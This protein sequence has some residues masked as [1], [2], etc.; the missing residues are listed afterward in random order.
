MLKVFSF[1][2][3]VSQGDVMQYPLQLVFELG[4][5]GMCVLFEVNKEFL[6]VITIVGARVRRLS[7]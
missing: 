7:A 2:S 4:R 3:L 1:F 6:L 5:Y